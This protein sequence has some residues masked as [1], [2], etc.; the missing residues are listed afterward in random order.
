MRRV[1]VIVALL[2]VFALS[3]VPLGALLHQ[4]LLRS[5]PEQG[6]EISGSPERIRLVFAESVE[7]TVTRVQLV[8]EGGGTIDLSPLTLEPDSSHVVLAHLIGPL[9]PGAYTVRWRTAGA[10]GHAMADSVLFSVVGGEDTSHSDSPVPRSSVGWTF[11]AGSP[12]YIIV[13]WA[14]FVG[15]LGVVGAVSFRLFIL[16]RVGWSNS[17]A[18]AASR[19][20]TEQSAATLGVAMATLVLVAVILRLYAQS[21]S[22][23]GPNESLTRGSL[24]SLLDTRWGSVWWIQLAAGVTALVGFLFARRRI[25][26]GWIL[27]AL[28]VLV[29]TFTPALSGHALTISGPTSLG[30]LADGV[31]VLAAGGW[32]GSLL[33]VL[34]VGIP[35][36][37][38][39]KAPVAALIRAFSP[40]ALTFAGLAVGTGILSAWLRLG[41]LPLLWTTEYGRTLL[42]KV[43]VL[44]VLFAIGAHNFLVVRPALRDDA[45]TPRLRRSATF[46]LLMAA[47]VLL[48]TAVLVATP[49]PA[50]LN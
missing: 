10:D 45:A 29:L 32:L 50:D 3:A 25:G 26:G 36:A 31:H 27:A 5:D 20:A 21:F 1:R 17:A 44:L 35:A 46:E 40:V 42:L 22:L 48:V 49:P 33:L 23:F 15:L 13:R 39:S 24:F 19:S 38:R 34:V 4:Q 14:L 41:T 16:P 37:M 28:G 2:S 30:V 8:R 9:A 18:S 7:L 47:L 43:G 12:G 11:D 6:E